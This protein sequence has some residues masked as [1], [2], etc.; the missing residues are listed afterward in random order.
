M[1]QNKAEKGKQKTWESTGSCTSI[2]VTKEASVDGSVM[3]THSCDGGYEF[4]LHIVPGETHKSGEMRPVYKGGGHGA[5]RDQAV[6]VGEIPEVKKTYSRFDIAYP[7]MNE[8][9]L[10]IGETTFGGRK[11][12]YNS[13]G[14]WDIMALQ[15]VALERASTA[16]EAIQLMGRLVEKYGY[17]DRGE[18]LTICDTKEAWVFE[19]L[20]AGPLQKGAVWAAQRV[21]EGE[22][23]VSANR[24]RIGEIDLKDK[25]N[26][27]AS[28]NVVELAQKKGWYDPESGKPF[29]FNKAYDPSESI[30]SRRREWRVLSTLAPNLNL[31]PWS[32]DYPFSVKPEKK[33]SVEELKSFHRDYYQG[34]QFDLSE[35][36][37]AG[38]FGNPNRFATWGKRPE[39]YVGWERSISIFRC[40]YCFVSQSRDWLPDWIGGLAWFALDDPKTSCFVPLYC[41]IS[42][43]PQSYQI[44]RRDEFNRNCA[45]WAFDFVSNWSNLKYS[46]IIKDIQKAYNDFESTFSNLQPAVEKRAQSLYKENPQACR[47][48]LTEYSNDMAKKVVRD[49][50]RLADYLIVKYNDGYINTPE[51]KKAVGYPDWWLDAVGYG[52]TKIKNK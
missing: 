33:V 51:G 10:A 15:R 32:V 17:G 4:R 45:W 24:S 14:M 49:W 48:Y 18:C 26:Y 12:L 20:G 35:G 31:D 50:W 36:M 19:I 6:K 25:D 44:G 5:E 7:F 9:Q 13:Q 27:M 3:T 47:E 34:T 23:F 16:R 2:T 28:D 46:Y 30:G 41:G 29:K 22:V 40:S 38:P 11:K 37:A 39:G 42:K 52:K 1:D 21:P 43:V 8:K